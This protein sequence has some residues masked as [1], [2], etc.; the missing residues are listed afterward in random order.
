MS[1]Y[2]ESA[3]KTARRELYLAK[4]RACVVTFAWVITAALL[5]TGFTLHFLGFGSDGGFV[6]FGLFTN[7]PF[8]IPAAW[9]TFFED[10][11]VYLKRQEAAWKYED[12]LDAHAK[13]VLS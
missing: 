13:S 6:A 11:R 5:V 4:R 10:K 1:L 8:S 9:W 3:V 2:T 7:L 12:A